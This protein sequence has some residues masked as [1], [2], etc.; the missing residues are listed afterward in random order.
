MMTRALLIFS[1]LALNGPAIAKN[2]SPIFGSSTQ[3]P[4]VVAINPRTGLPVIVADNS[5]PVVANT[6]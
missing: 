5:K 2:P 6:Q 4:V 1:L 3:A